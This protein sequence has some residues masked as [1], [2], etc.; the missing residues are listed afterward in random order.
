MVRPG[1]IMYTRVPGACHYSAIDVE[2]VKQ[3]LL[4]AYSKGHLSET[5]GLTRAGFLIWESVRSTLTSVEWLPYILVSWKFQPAILIFLF[6]VSVS[7][8]VSV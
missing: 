6:L 1:A 4:L 7:R 8:T 2:V 5:I 3:L